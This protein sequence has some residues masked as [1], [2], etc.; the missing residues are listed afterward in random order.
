MTQKTNRFQP[1]RRRLL[2]VAGTALFASA[3]SGCGFRLRGR[4]EAPFESLYLDMPANSLF[5]AHL[6]NAIEAGSS[7]KCVNSLQE[8]DAV[9]HIVS[10]SRG[11]DILTVNDLGKT[12]EYE[13]TLRIAF[14]CTSP[15]DGF[16]FI[17]TTSLATSR[18]LPYTESEF[19]S[20]EKESEVLYRDMENDL[21]IQI[22][23]RL[24]ASH[25]PKGEL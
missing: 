2:C 16:E 21:V 17:E 20:R 25:K 7:V 14:N 22:V 11:S 1:T 6:K 10:Q 5:T 24:A 18:V 4:F 12:R 8:A 15:V 23:R 19:L 13:L 9:L 3:L